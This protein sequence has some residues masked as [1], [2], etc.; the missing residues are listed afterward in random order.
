MRTLA[1]CCAVLSLAGL[2]RAQTP[3]AAAPDGAAGVAVEKHSWSKERIGWERDPFGGPVEGFEETRRRR[4]DER[5]LERARSTGNVGE[6]SKVEREMRAEQVIKSRSSPPPRY[7]FLYKI[8]VR[9][10][11]AK[12]IRELDLDYVFYDAATGQELGRRQ[13]TGIEKIAPGK[14]KELSFFAPT[15]PVH[16]ISVH[17]LDRKEREGLRG[18]AVVVRVL[19]ADGTFW[20]SPA[21]PQSPVSAAP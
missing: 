21:P 13:F 19:Y 7:A 10:T 15:P 14:R 20:A 2:A 8:S 17:A 3:D 16:R 6:A 12:A 18:E 11:G 1:L 5:R 4:V 9:N